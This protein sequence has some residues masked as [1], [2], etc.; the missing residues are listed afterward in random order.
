MYFDLVALLADCSI[1]MELQLT[2]ADFFL[3]YFL[4]GYNRR[5]LEVVGWMRDY[6]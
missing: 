5:Q 1:F 4:V 6:V 2:R 3:L